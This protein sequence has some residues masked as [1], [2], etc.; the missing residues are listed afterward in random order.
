[1]RRPA[2]DP[3]E[4]ETT[5]TERVAPDEPKLHLLENGEYQPD[6]VH[7]AI[8]DGKFKPVAFP[9]IAKLDQRQYAVMKCGA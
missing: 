8:R 1:M 7:S 2:R 3:S 6:T 9:R 4:T 5:A